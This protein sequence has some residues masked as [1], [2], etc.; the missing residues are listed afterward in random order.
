MR[1]APRE[2]VATRGGCCMFGE[3]GTFVLLRTTTADGTLP[4][5]GGGRWITVFRDWRKRSCLRGAYP[6]R[7]L[8]Y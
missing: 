3:V 8:Q 1:A 6:S 7:Y 5:P 2:A 4:R